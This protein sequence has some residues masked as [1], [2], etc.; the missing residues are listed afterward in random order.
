LDKGYAK[1]FEITGDFFN[2]FVFKDSSILCFLI[3]WV[4]VGAGPLLEE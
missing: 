2:N 4:E 3:F 1:L